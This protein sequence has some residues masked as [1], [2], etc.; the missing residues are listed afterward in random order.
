MNATAAFASRTFSIGQYECTLTVPRPKPGHVVHA[1]LDWRPQ[2][3][4]LTEEEVT[5]YRQGRNKALAEISLELGIN[6]AV[7]EI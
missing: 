4:K 2:P 1:S 7:L 6:S 3:R 5:A